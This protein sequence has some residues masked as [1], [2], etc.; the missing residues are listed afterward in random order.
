MNKKCHALAQYVPFIMFVVNP[1]RL[2]SIQTK[3]A[4]A[5][6]RVTQDLKK[7]WSI[8]IFKVPMLRHCFDMEKMTSNQML[9]LD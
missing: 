8:D 6:Y 9:I 2:R 1:E 7:R 4:A 3:M 5:G